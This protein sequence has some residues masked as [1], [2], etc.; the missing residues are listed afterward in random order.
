[1]RRHIIKL[2]EPGDNVL[3]QPCELIEDLASAAEVVDDLWD[4]LHG[5]QEMYNFSRG[6]GLA[7]PQIGELVQATVIDFGG[8]EEYTLLNPELVIHSDEQVLVPEGCMSFFDKR[9]RALRSLEVTLHG[10][11]L[12][13]DEVVVESRGDPN[14]ASLMEHEYG[15]LAGK[16]YLEVMPPGEELYPKSDMPTF[17]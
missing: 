1:M 10:V 16:L 3:H 4:T 8:G 2:G 13:G 7:A 15:H 6:S 5:A 17:Y 11:D 9:G 14:R 12:R